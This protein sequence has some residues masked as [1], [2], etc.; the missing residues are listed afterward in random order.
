MTDPSAETHLQHPRVTFVQISDNSFLFNSSSFS[1][2][3][4]N[5][6]STDHTGPSF[7]FSVKLFQQPSADVT[8]PSVNMSTEPEP[9]TR[10]TV[11]ICRP[12]QRAAA[13]TQRENC[14]LLQLLAMRWVFVTLLLASSGAEGKGCPD[15]FSDIENTNGIWSIHGGKLVKEESNIG[16]KAK[17]KVRWVKTSQR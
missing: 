15:R 7:K 1:N 9:R 6:S 14:A 2:P 16:G 5:S 10:P 12:C 11:Y 17:A 13:I 8:P 3:L 4:F